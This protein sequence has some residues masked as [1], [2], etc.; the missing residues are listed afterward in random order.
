[1]LSPPP[2]RGAQV[3]IVW[4]GSPGFVHDRARSLGVD[5][6]K[7]LAEMLGTVLQSLQMPVG[8][9]G[10]L[11]ILDRMVGVTDFADTAARIA[12]LDLVIAVDSA[13]AHL[14]A[15]M[16]KE[17]WLLS[18]FLGCWRWLRDQADS[19]WYPTLR[20]YRQPSAGDWTSVVERVSLDLETWVSH[21]PKI[22]IPPLRHTST[23]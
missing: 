13:V 10:D 4:A 12:G 3:G 7:A 8:S 1:L 15:A 23:A 17:V 20:V 2:V 5:A 6:L 16:G 22:S 11:P 14:A 19:P 9:T 21:G 18:R